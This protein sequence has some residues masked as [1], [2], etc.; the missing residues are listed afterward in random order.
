MFQ[1]NIETG[2]GGGRQYV[3]VA[4]S[5]ASQINSEYTKQSNTF[6]G[7]E[8]FI[9]DNNSTYCIVLVPAFGYDL[10]MI[11]ETSYVVANDG[12]GAV[13]ALYYF[14]MFPF[15]EGPSDPPQSEWMDMDFSPHHEITVSAVMS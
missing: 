8:W 13:N 7:K 9:N 6:N 11:T 15:G 3:T 1:P 2:G 12:D 4:G 10:W 14:T 5:Y